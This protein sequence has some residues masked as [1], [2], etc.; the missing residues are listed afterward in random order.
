MA[1]KDNKKEM[2]FEE[3]G[4][5]ISKTEQFIENNQQK[6]IKVTGIIF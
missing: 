5:A 1:K 6:I 2:Q 4:E 3:V